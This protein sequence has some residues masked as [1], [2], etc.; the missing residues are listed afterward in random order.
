MNGRRESH[1]AELAGRPR[2]LGRDALRRGLSLLPSRTSSLHLVTYSTLSLL[3]SSQSWVLG[4]ISLSLSLSRSSLSP[5]QYSLFPPLLLLPPWTL[6]PSNLKV[7]T[8]LCKLQPL[9]PSCS[10]VSSRE[11]IRASPLSSCSPQGEKPKAPHL[12]IG[13]LSPRVTEY[14]LQEIFAVAGE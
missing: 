4:V 6:S 13:G 9:L 7:L 5:V 1:A 8:S 10:L 11:L 3:L 2:Q 14:M 12:Y